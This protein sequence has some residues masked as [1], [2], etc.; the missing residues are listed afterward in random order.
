M[1]ADATV[2]NA[3]LSGVKAKDSKPS[4][5]TEKQKD[6]Q[7]RRDLRQ[8]IQRK[9]FITLWVQ[10]GA[11]LLLMLFQG[12]KWGGFSLNDWA[13]GFLANGTLI[14]TFFIVRFIVQHLFP[15]EG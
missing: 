14:E 4:P 1:N 5:I 11:L 8:T 15:Q 13:F 3:A 6:S 12:F 9:V 2:L 10:L 7:Q